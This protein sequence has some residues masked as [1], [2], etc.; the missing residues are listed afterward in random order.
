MKRLVWLI[1]VALLVVGVL[2]FTYT[3]TTSA[4]G[5]WVHPKLQMLSTS[6]DVPTFGGVGV[7]P[8]YQTLESITFS[9]TG[10]SKMEMTAFNSLSWSFEFTL[11]GKV[12]YNG[13]TSGTYQ[14]NY[15]TTVN[16]IAAGTHNVKVIAYDACGCGET[17]GPHMGGTLS[18]IVST[19]L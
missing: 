3:H 1:P 9:V 18:L 11:D 7:P 15:T 16:N 10:T 13:W 5:N 4:A 17:S 14:T 8:L 2:S 6:Y 19:G 12:L